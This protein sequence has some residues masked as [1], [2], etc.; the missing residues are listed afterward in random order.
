MFGKS[1]IAD[2]NLI[3]ND[4]GEPCSNSGTITFSGKNGSG[5]DDGV[6][7]IGGLAGQF[8]AINK[9]EGGFENSGSIIFNGEHNGSDLCIGGIAGNNGV[10]PYKADGTRVIDDTLVFSGE[11]IECSGTITKGTPYIGGIFGCSTQNIV[12]AKVFTN[13]SAVGFTNVGM[14]TGSARVAGTVVAS[15]CA[16]GGMI[17]TSKTGEGEAERLNEI[18]LKAGTYFNYIYG[19]ADWTGVADYDGCGYIDSIDDD[20]PDYA[21]QQPAE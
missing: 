16:V 1:G 12:D 7:Y 11:K 20:T 6:L 13:I 21:T 4:D 14:I 10:A 9:I 15:N 18:E 3:K 17:C 19:S 2:T 8:T 5:N